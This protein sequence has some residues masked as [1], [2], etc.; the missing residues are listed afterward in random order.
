MADGVMP[1][2]FRLEY[3]VLLPTGFDFTQAINNFCQV[4]ILQIEEAEPEYIS[5]SGDDFSFRAKVVNSNSGGASSAVLV[6]V[7]AE[8]EYSLQTAKEM[9]EEKTGAV[10]ANAILLRDSV[11][12][13]RTIE[14][15]KLINELENALR[16]LVALRLASLSGQNWWSNRVQI[17]FQQRRGCYQYENYRNNEVNDPEVTPPNEQYH[18]DLFYIDLSE[19][20]KVIEEQRNWQ[21]GFVTDLKVLKS[22]EWLDMLNRLRR[23]IAHNRFLSQRNLDDLRTIHGQLMHLCR[24]LD[25]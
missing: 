8:D 21:D 4:F 12:E 20:K 6:L 7:E 19:L 11:G 16:K 9:I 25:F 15:Y 23:K 10:F 13:A 14:A 24:R 2:E 5:G 3:L 18:H 17:N 1:L 22:I